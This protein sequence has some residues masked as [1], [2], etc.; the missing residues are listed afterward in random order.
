MKTELLPVK[1]TSAELLTKGEELAEAIRVRD[2]HEANA[3]D[4][5]K[6]AKQRLDE[7]DT[8]VTKLAGIVRRK[9]ENRPVEVFEKADAGRLI[10]NTIRADTFE[11]VGY[12]PMRMEER[13]ANLF[14][15]DGNPIVADGAPVSD[16]DADRN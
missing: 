1:L 11:V 16:G 10:V 3:K 5:A 8:D 13:N 15:A 12:R 9:A 2:E 7:L 14:D 4:A 6:A